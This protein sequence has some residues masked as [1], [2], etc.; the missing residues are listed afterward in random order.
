MHHTI[1]GI[2]LGESIIKDSDVFVEER[3]FDVEQCLTEL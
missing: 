1:R 3:I 2:S